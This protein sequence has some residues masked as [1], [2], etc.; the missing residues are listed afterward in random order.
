MSSVYAPSHPGTQAASLP[1]NS[2][3]RKPKPRKITQPAQNHTSGTGWDE[4]PPARPSSGL[5]GQLR[6]GLP[7]VN[8]LRSSLLISTETSPPLPGS[9]A[10]NNPGVVLECSFSQ[11]LLAILMGPPAKQA[12]FLSAKGV[13]HIL[14]PGKM[15]C[16]ELEVCHKALHPHTQLSCSS[17][18][19]DRTA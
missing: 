9:C 17:W 6:N 7:S 10:A 8:L 18:R 19:Y 13:P 11:S 16:L 12:T 15:E 5:R 2:Q 4:E 14:T 1:P 3:A